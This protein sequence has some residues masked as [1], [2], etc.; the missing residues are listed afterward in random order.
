MTRQTL[1]DLG[2]HYDQYV[3][4]KR[5]K[6]AGV[7]PQAEWGEPR[8]KR[9]GDRV[10]IPLTITHDSTV[11]SARFTGERTIRISKMGDIW[12][13]RPFPVNHY[14]PK[15]ARLFQTA[16]R[17]WRMTISCEVPDP[18]PCAGEPVV[19]GLDRNIGNAATPDHVITIPEKVVRRMANAGQAARRVQRTMERRQKPDGKNRKPGSRRWAKAAKRYARKKRRAANIRK[20]ISHKISKVVAD[21]NTHAVVEDIK[22]KDMTKS[23]KGTR[24]NPGKNVRQKAGLNRAILEQCW[25]MLVMMLAYK[26]V[27]GVIRVPAAYT[28]QMC[29]R[30][31]FTDRLNRDGREF[32]CLMCHHVEHADRNAGKN[33]EDAGVRKLGRP[34]RRGSIMPSSYA[35]YPDTIAGSAHVKGCLDVEGSGVGLPQKRQAQTAEAPSSGVVVLWRDV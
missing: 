17:K 16:D 22:P 23:A 6:A 27:G 20:T 10:S 5:L 35:T 13:S 2:R 9:R 34:C 24:E 8:F 33:I 1:H 12:L 29:G 4:T 3:E 28:S 30:C 15:T 31:G 11:G 18:E 19:I 7:T 14:R 26:M 25:G 32:L 21:G